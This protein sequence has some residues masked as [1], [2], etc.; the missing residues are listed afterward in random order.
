MLLM[1]VAETLRKYCELH[2]RVAKD[3]YG[4]TLAGLNNENADLTAVVNSNRKFGRLLHLHNK[5]ASF[6][7][8]TLVVCRY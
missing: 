3:V 1:I 8:F 4:L 6:D 5:S 2:I 7:F